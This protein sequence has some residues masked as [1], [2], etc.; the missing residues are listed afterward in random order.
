MKIRWHRESIYLTCAPTFYHFLVDSFDCFDLMR[1]LDASVDFEHKVI[2]DSIV[3]PD[4]WRGYNVL[5]VC[6]FRH[7]RINHSKL[8]ADKHNHI[9]GIENFWSAP[10]AQI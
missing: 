6:K 3:Y 4:C 10:Y 7:F 2:P 5:D 1:S 9:N 8:F